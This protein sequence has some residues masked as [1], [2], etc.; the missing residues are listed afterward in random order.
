[1][2]IRTG[3][4]CFLTDQSVSIVDLAIE[5]EA[6]C[7]TELWVPEHTH[8]PTGRETD[9]PME[10]DAELPEMYKR[11]MDPFI[12]LTAAAMATTTLT[13]GTSICL[14]GQHD[15]IVLA[16]TISTL[17]HIA[18]GRII[19]GVGFGW[20][21]DEMRNHGVDPDRRRTIG[22]EKV[23]AMKELWTKDEASFHGKYVDFSPSWQ[24][25]KPVQTPHPPVWVG[26]GKSTMKH[27]VEWG[28]GWMPIE[29]VMPVA[30][31]TVRLR[32]MAEDAGRDPSEITVYLSGAPKDPAKLE[33]YLE[34]G[35]DG[36]ALGVSWD[37][38]L[39]TAKRE[40]D[41]NVEFRDRYLS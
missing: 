19:L 11:S 24:W 29:G 3:I 37:A 2:S 28:D 26:G 38:D 7:F 23:L 14:V 1:V 15:P 32:Q 16:K 10:D 31:L 27:A 22:R 20:N 6:R 40:L 34:A 12:A 25:P 18:N 36:I 4:S 5:T 33:S 30:K 9:W 41:E 17:D 39:D 21:E 13:L 8:I 35:L